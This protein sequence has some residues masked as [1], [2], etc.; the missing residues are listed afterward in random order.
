MYKILSKLIPEKMDWKLALKKIIPDSF[1]NNIFL[2]FPILYKNR[3]INYQTN[4]CKYEIYELLYYLARACKLE[5]NIIECGSNKCGTSIIIA[6]Y[7]IDNE[8][9]SKRIYACDTFSGFDMSELSEDISKGYTNVSKKAFT[10]TS[11]EYVNKKIMKLKLG[12][13]VIP[14]KGLFQDTLHTIDS[15]FCL[16][17]IDCDLEKSTTYCAEY[18]FSKIEKNGFMLFD[19]YNDR[20]FQGVRIA[21]DRFVK[22]Y[23][24]NIINIGLLKRFYVIQKI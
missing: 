20:N 22:K 4:L 21:V 16:A 2:A 15:K 1:L 6:N 13:I 3:I 14:V 8:I 10:S 19:D 9:K 5:G 12:H 17:F 11:Y 23:H 18:L 24:H 7:L